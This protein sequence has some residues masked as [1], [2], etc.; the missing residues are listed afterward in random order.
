[1]LSLHRMRIK[2]RA[3]KLQRAFVT[4]RDNVNRINVGSV[5]QRSSNLLDT[6]RIALQEDHIGVTGHD[7]FGNKV[8][9]PI[10]GFV[11]ENDL[12]ALV[13]GRGS[14]GALFGRRRCFRCERILD[15]SVGNLQGT[16]WD[17]VEKDTI[18]K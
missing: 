5:F 13:S 17:G 9:K 2:R 18:L 7:Q 10:D 16:I 15:R 8:L 3:T 14:D 1:M 12:V 6:V 4:V 11:D